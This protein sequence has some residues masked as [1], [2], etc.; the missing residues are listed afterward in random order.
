VYLCPKPFS[1]R[2]GREFQQG[3]EIVL[4][5]SKIK[6]GEADLTVAR[7]VAKGSD[8]LVL[9]DAKWNTARAQSNGLGSRSFRVAYKSN[10]G[11]RQRSPVRIEE[12]VSGSFTRYRIQIDVALPL[13]RLVQ[14]GHRLRKQR[15][16]KTIQHLAI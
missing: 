4:T 1:R 10:M 9:R 11:S 15:V 2:H 7:E 3:D 12:I 13:V 16:L 5:G 14:G 6:Q 8:T